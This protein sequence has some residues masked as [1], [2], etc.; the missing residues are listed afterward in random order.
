MTLGRP[1]S[2]RFTDR[3]PNVDL[4]TVGDV[5]YFRYRFP[6]G[7]RRLIG[8]SRDRQ[9]AYEIAIAL[10]AHFA[11]QQTDLSKFLT[12]R[13]VSASSRNPTLATVINSYRDRVLARRRLSDRTRSEKEIK[14]RLYKKKWGD[15]TVSEFETAD[16]SEFLDTLTPAAYIKHR[17]ELVKLF[18][19]A[20]HQGWRTTNPVAVTMTIEEGEK[21]RQR[22]TTEGLKA[23]LKVA[24][25][26]LSRAIRLGLWS[27]QRRDDIVNLHRLHNHVDLEVG[28]IHVLQRKT[29]N[30]T[31]PV[32]IEI[33]M[34]RDLVDVVRECVASDVPCPYLVHRRPK[35]QSAKHR[36]AKPHPFAVSPKY[37]S[38]EFT[39][40]R[41]AV[42]VYDYLEPRQ[43]PT[44]HELRAFGAHLYEQAGYSRE[45]I[46]ALSGH[47]TD[48][49]LERYLKDHAQPQARRVHAGDRTKHI[50]F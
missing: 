22:H 15:R 46:R 28:T 6:D 25:P 38:D 18:Q 16:F 48:A 5:T 42:G 37:L 47:A 44:Y 31:N 29:R 20:C 4:N 49:M 45:Y 41:D 8:D 35:R 21:Q 2:K 24:E 14:L 23:M 12:P 11:S 36:Q 26:W 43:R 13:S 7:R 33:V 50:E 10:N 27:L 34:G 9:K 30:Y 3:P 19:F 17:A 40:L 1:R 39:A 32:Y